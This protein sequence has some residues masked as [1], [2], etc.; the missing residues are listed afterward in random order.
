MDLDRPTANS[1]KR[2]SLSRAPSKTD[3][4]VRRL[5]NQH[6]NPLPSRTNRDSHKRTTV[7]RARDAV[8]DAGETMGELVA[9]VRKVS[10]IISEISRAADRQSQGIGEVGAAVTVLDQMTQQNA[11]L[12]EQS[13]AAAESLKNQARQLSE[14][15]ATFRLESSS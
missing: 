6:R 9:S 5:A 11:A 8:V 10:D 12:V 3:A 13:A 2:K 14:V 15:V 7:D 4:P 1:G